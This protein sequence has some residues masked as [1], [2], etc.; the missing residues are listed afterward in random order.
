MTHRSRA[1]YVLF[2]TLLLGFGTMLWGQVGSV[3]GTLKDPSGAVVPNGQLVLTSKATAA[4]PA[5]PCMMPTASGR[6][7]W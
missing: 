6:K 2:L 3:T 4:E 5:S 1:S 7:S